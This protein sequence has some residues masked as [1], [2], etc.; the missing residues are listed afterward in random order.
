MDYMAY[1]QQCKQL[2]SMLLESKSV[3]YNSK[4]NEASWNQN[5]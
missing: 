1:K 3:Y 4:V 2:N 5:E